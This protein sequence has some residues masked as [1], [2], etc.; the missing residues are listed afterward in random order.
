MLRTPE[1]DDS[2]EMTIRLRLSTSLSI[3]P[4]GQGTDSVARANDRIPADL[5]TQVANLQSLKTVLPAETSKSATHA[6]AC[7]SAA[8]AIANDSAT[9]AATNDICSYS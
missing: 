5:Q 3:P 2:R 4:S 8:H 9:S 1:P 6:I 7:D